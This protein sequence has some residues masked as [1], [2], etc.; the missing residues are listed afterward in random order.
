MHFYGGCQNDQYPGSRQL[1]QKKKA[2]PA[3]V[4]GKGKRLC[5][6]SVG[7]RQFWWLGLGLGGVRAYFPEPPSKKASVTKALATPPKGPVRA[8]RVGGGGGKA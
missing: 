2:R 5:T 1:N 4:Q 8:V 7:K 3:G 6:E